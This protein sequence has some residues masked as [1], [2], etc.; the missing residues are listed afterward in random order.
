[1]ETRQ[2]LG[3]SVLVVAAAMSVLPPAFGLGAPR[4]ADK[5]V[6]GLTGTYRRGDTSSLTVRA[7]PG[8][9]RVRFALS[10]LAPGAKPDTAPNTGD[11]SGEAMLQGGGNAVYRRD[12]CTITMRFRG[13]EA[14]LKQF[15]DAA[16]CDFGSG[17]EATG[18]YR[19]IAAKK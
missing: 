14:T 9:K 4:E 6:P 7:L 18:T 1:M 16:D 10:L 19:R 15:G 11:A 2:C 3:A 5:P 17:V 8:G 12:R 13:D